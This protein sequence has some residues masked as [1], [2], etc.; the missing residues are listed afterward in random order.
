MRRELLTETSAKRVARIKLT[1]T[2]H[3]IEALE[4]AEKSWLAWDDELT[5]FGVR[6][7]P[8]SYTRKLVT[9]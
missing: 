8:T 3:T 7:Q 2:E 6:V 1:L 9:R 5:G 4:P